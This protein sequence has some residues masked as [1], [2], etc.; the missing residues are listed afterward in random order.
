MCRSGDVW[1]KHVAEH[2]CG[3]RFSVGP[4]AARQRFHSALVNATDH[5]LETLHRTEQSM[6]ISFTLERH[7]AIEKLLRSA[8][9]APADFWRHAPATEGVLH[10][11]HHLSR[12]SAE[13]VQCGERLDSVAHATCSL[14]PLLDCAQ[15][16]NMCIHACSAD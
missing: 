14:A 8:P 2:V 16:C 10:R 6:H 4:M 13:R 12:V 5:T 11:L 1:S 3:I 7:D 9:T 15:V